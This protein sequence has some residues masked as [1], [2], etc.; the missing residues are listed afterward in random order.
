GKAVAAGVAA[1]GVAAAGVAA[2]AAKK[3]DS[4]PDAEPVT[5]E[6]TAPP[7]APVAPVAPGVPGETVTGEVPPIPTVDGALA[8][9]TVDADLDVDPTARGTGDRPAGGPL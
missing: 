8:D 9:D 1:A 6:S 4:G 7:A 2:A 3:K 5:F